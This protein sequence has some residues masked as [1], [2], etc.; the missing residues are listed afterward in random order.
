MK[1]TVIPFVIG[2]LGS[3][4]KRFLKRVD[5]LE[6]WT[7]VESWRLEETCYYSNPSEKPSVNAGVKNSQIIIIIIILSPLEIVQE[8]RSAL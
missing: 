1:A 4:L 5:G 7:S 3:I 6:M 2:E 8:V